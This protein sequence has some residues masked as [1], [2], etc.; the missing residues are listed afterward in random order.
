MQSEP[1]KSEWLTPAELAERWKISP[2]AARRYIHAKEHP[3]DP[4][5]RGKLPGFRIGGARLLRVH[6]EDVQAHEARKSPEVKAARAQQNRVRPRSLR[7]VRD[8]FA[9][10]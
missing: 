2:A 6:I 9:D 4:V 5:P 7:L 3:D 8:R 1:T 10:L